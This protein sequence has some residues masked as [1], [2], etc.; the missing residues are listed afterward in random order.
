MGNLVFENRDIDVSK[1]WA[2]EMPSEDTI[3]LGSQSLASLMTSKFYDIGYLLDALDMSLDDLSSFFIEHGITTRAHRIVQLTDD[4]IQLFARFFVKEV[5]RAC[6]KGKF[7]NRFVTTK[8]STGKDPIGILQFGVPLEEWQELFL[9]EEEI[10]AWFWSIL[11]GYNP[12]E[13]LRIEPYK[14]YGLLKRV[15]KKIKSKLRKRGRVID[16]R[17]EFFRVATL[18]Q[19]YIFPEEDN[20][21]S[22]TFCT[23]S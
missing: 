11:D 6:R 22:T 7:G 12:T 5:K 19:F 9:D 14:V 18:H 21:S 4:E 15:S 23:T 13:G 20:S 10:Y 2:Y 1:P 8:A 17:W 3:W 16:A